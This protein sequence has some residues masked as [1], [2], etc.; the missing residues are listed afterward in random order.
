MAEDE[1][2]GE[3]EP[4]VGIAEINVNA[5]MRIVSGATAPPGDGYAQDR[6]QYEADNKR[7]PNQRQCQGKSRAMTLVTGSALANDVPKS[8]CARLVR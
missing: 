1:D 7:H 2:Q 3:R 6:A 5:G 8:P 4:E